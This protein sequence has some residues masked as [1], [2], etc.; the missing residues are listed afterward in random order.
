MLS[1]ITL[2]FLRKNILKMSLAYTVEHSL[3]VL[4]NGFWELFFMKKRLRFRNLL[5]CCRE[6]DF[7]F[8]GAPVLT[9]IRIGEMRFRFSL[10]QE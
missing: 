8:G 4:L 5:R 3:Q 6:K 10:E 2:F 9:G 7:S 1:K